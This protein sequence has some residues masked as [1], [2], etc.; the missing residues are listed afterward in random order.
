MSG[1]G[2]RFVG[3]CMQGSR[4][5]VAGWQRT[6]SHSCWFVSGLCSKGWCF[7]AKRGIDMFR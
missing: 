2:F 5:F 1:S 4:F 6:V 3:I 7:L